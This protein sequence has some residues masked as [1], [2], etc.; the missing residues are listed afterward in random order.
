[1]DKKLKAKCV[2]ALRSGEYKQGV[3]FLKD[4]D[5]EKVISYCC[6]GV[7]Q[8][9]EPKI[10]RSVNSELLGSS[11]GIDIDT[12]CKLAAMND[13]LGQKKKSFRAIANWIEK[14]L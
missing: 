13:G 12:Q 8:T 1:M 14:N 4:T 5:A 7:L 3:G 10:R 2:N 9:I 11:C 6:L